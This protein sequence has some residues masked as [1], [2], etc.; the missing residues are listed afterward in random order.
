MGGW[1]WKKMLA[2]MVT[3][4]PMAAFIESRSKRVKDA[5]G[6]LVYRDL[7]VRNRSQTVTGDLVRNDYYRTD[8]TNTPTMIAGEYVSYDPAT[9]SGAYHIFAKPVGMNTIDTTNVMNSAVSF[10]IPKTI[11]RSAETEVAYNFRVWGNSNLDNVNAANINTVSVNTGDLTASG[12]AYLNGGASITGVA[13]VD[14]AATVEGSFTS[15]GA[16]NFNGPS[17]FFENK[18]AAKSGIKTGEYNATTFLDVTNE[19]LVFSDKWRMYLDEANNELLIQQ[20]VQ[21]NNVW[22]WETKFTFA[23]EAAA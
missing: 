20:R 15:N 8:G 10:S 7:Y 16:A 12:T 17:P 18:L 6:D 11:L 5:L 21:I 23:A 13:L 4:P 9:E 2:Y 14:G 1:T 3:N 22:T 19:A